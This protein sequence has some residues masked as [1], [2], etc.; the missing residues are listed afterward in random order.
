MRRH[1]D[2]WV[3]VSG[4]S[5][6]RSSPQ[7]GSN[8]TLATLNW[9]DLTAGVPNNYFDPPRTLI[10]GLFGRGLP[11]YGSLL[12][13]PHQV[14]LGDPSLVPL[15]TH[16]TTYTRLRSAV[17]MLLETGGQ[18]VPPCRAFHNACDRAMLGL[19]LRTVIRPSPSPEKHQLTCLHTGRQAAMPCM[20]G[21]Y[22]ALALAV[23]AFDAFQPPTSNENGRSRL[24]W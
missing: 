16:G 8:K 7:N 20:P 10:R 13:P 24:R 21:A 3:P 22:C 6:R 5:G 23:L 14:R 12:S 17:E 18:V 19:A 15:P 11:V 4:N 1:C 9:Y 2:T